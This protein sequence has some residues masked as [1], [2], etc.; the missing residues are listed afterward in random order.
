MCC[1]CFSGL[2][3][4]I[5]V[6]VFVQG[7][8]KKSLCNLH[9]TFEGLCYCRLR[10]PYLVRDT[11]L[12]I[13]T[14][15]IVCIELDRKNCC[16]NNWCTCDFGTWSQYW[17]SLWNFIHYSNSTFCQSCGQVRKCQPF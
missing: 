7:Y 5:A 1:N 15:T 12:F 16:S 6:A 10:L 17:N 13:D 8:D 2:W 3:S 11:D 4:L 14:S 9:A